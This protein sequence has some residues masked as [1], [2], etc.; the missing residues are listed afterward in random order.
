MELAR[1]A[2]WL[3]VLAVVT[4]LVGAVPGRTVAGTP[5][6]AAT[7]RYI[8]VLHPGRASATPPAQGSS[9]AVPRALSSQGH[10]A[11]S[12][13][14]QRLL[15]QLDIRPSRT[16]HV[17][18]DGFA[19]RLTAVQL[20][21]LRATPSVAAVVPDV[22]T[23]VE[24]PADGGP[25]GGIVR[26]TH[27]PHQVLPTG[28]RRVNAD[29][30][31]IAKIDGVDQRV[32]VDVAIIDTGIAPHPDLSIAGG[33]DCTSKDPDVYRDRYG[34]GTH[35][36][37]IV[38]AL[39]NKIGV[40][41]MAPG[42]RLWAVK[43]FGD[44]GRGY[45]SWYVCGIDWMMSLRDPQDPSRPRI[46][47]ANM[48]L[49]N[50]LPNADDSNCG[51][52]SGDILHQAICAAVA[53][54]TTIVVAAGNDSN[55]A[56]L[57]RPAAYDE[58]ITVSALADFDGLPG[59]HGSQAFICPWY[60]PDQDDTFGDFSNFGA[61][62]DL[63]A[64][65]KCIL[66]TYKDGLYSWETGTSMASPTVA[67]AAA[68]VAAVN[69]GARPG[70]IKQALI[71][72]ADGKWKT[73][74]DP[75]GHPDPLLD[76]AHLGPLPSFTVS[77]DPP[78]DEVG[79]GGFTTI[80]VHLSRSNGETA[81][82]SLSTAGLPG[83]VDAEFEPPHTTG[84][85]AT[86]TLRAT[87]P[88]SAGT[89]SIQVRAT[90]GARTDSASVDVVIRGGGPT[91]HFARPPNGTTIKHATATTISW[92][93]H[94][95]GPPPGHRQ[96][97]RQRA[98]PTT[99]GS[100][101]GVDWQNDGPL[102][103]AA[104]VDPGGSVADG[105]SFK[106]SDLVPDGCYRWFVRLTNGDG[107]SA[108]WASGAVLVD[109]HAPPPPLVT[110]RGQ[111]VFQ[112][113]PIATIWVRGGHPGTLHLTA[114]GTDPMSGV[115]SHDFGSPSHSTGWTVL[116]SPQSGDPVS[117]ELHWGSSAVNTTI[118]VRSTDRAGHTG[119]VRTVVIRVDSGRPSAPT[120]KFPIPGYTSMEDTP[121]LHWANGTDSGSGFARLQLVQRLRGPIVKAGSCS[122]VAYSKDRPA[123]LLDRHHEE[124]DL[125]SGF[126]YRWVLTPLDNVG[127]T[128][129]KVTSGTV[130]LDRTPPTANFLAPDEGTLT[131][132]SSYT[133][134]VRWTQ[135]ESG[136]SGGIVDRSLERERGKVVHAG[137]CDGVTWRVDGPTDHGASPSAQSG[138]LPG[139]CYRW[140]IN[141]EDRATNVGSYLSGRVLVESSFARVDRLA[142]GLG[143]QWSGGTARSSRAVAPLAVS[144]AARLGGDV[145]S[146]PPSASRLG[147]WGAPRPRRQM[148]LGWPVATAWM[149]RE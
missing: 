137:T 10:A 53:D 2:T 8:V 148:G 96:V 124:A 105:W 120:W 90:D 132:Q 130:L 4:L 5:P 131:S 59:G 74:T 58:V 111:N 86:L 144:N 50:W 40:V 22:K 100:C 7:D 95:P 43:V 97:R 107:T 146:S 102:L 30:S 6:P 115:F 99:P 82:L 125:V 23:R 91:V 48:S 68:L 57:R 19:A 79:P 104:S 26:T 14:I 85:E 127:N 13:E 93:E 134:T 81:A 24:T 94:D 116:S 25:Q 70:Q 77:A 62:V 83:G 67:G 11:A 33:H 88:L 78:S 84:N 143:D 135:H 136:G 147:A 9:A 142:L 75:D 121:D 138:L 51:K 31:P 32:D 17:A 72:A 129:H 38:G 73:S 118:A 133:F 3:T 87:G 145:W 1:R 64:P 110:G 37:G 106:D 108:A 27:L 92:S 60:S 15:T 71:H 112:S 126:C 149:P 61:D 98:D 36:A 46:E 28:I 12:R 34:H 65:G 117:I 114:H 109:T 29:K 89:D 101:A 18:L 122:G 44:A 123:R 141:L 56:A 54:G 80:P 55:S 42:A 49:D 140:R 63:I 16:F 41:G 35:V 20:A 66:S 139:Y 113:G 76:A 103:D 45:L 128:G 47:V 21:A 52:S 119:P 69:P 39:D